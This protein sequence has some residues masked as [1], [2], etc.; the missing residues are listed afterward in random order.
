MK[1]MKGMRP[2]SPFEQYDAAPTTTTDRFL[3]GKD[4]AEGIAGR[5]EID[6]TAEQGEATCSTIIAPHR[7]K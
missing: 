1:K 4:L 3:A 5:V 7:R 6:T 2:L